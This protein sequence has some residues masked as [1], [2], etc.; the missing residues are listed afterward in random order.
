MRIKDKLNRLLH[1][2]EVDR[3]VLFGLLTRFWQMLTGPVTL[4]LIARHMKPE[5][6]GFYY[7]FASLL[8]LQSFVE[9]GF[10]VVIIN[11]AS[12]E[13]ASLKLDNIGRI[14]GES[15]ALSRLVSLGRLTFKWYAAASAI[16]VVGVGAAGFVF[17]SQ[18]S[19]PGIHWQFPW[20]VLVLLAGG[21][22]WAL[23]F[24]SLLEG[25]N[26]MGTV[27]RFRLSQVVLETAA[28]WIVLTLGGGLWAAVASG[29]VKW[30]RDLYLLLVQYRKFFEP[31]FRHPDGAQ[32]SWKDEV[33]PMQWRLALAGVVNYFAFSLFTPVM[34]QYHGAVVA[35]QMGMTWTIVGAVQAVALIWVYTKVPKFGMLIAQKDFVELDR[36]WLRTSLVSIVVV[37]AGAVGAWTLF[38]AL[39][40]WHIRFADRLLGPLPLGLLLT[41]VVLMQFTQCETAYLRAHKR[42]PLMVLSVV[43]GILS[44]G[45]VWFL[46]RRFGPTGAAAGY[47]AVIAFVNLPWETAIWFK[48]RAAW[49]ET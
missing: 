31:F 40:M 3:A 24:N 21:T 2:A 34:F 19:Y 6:Q 32:I 20:L 4:L 28:L 33:F 15:H 26:Q 13:W 29:A 49:H 12:H 5:V 39:N 14:C 18:K 47:L 11:V 42:E 41:S 44:G 1:H 27:N 7:T 23:P 43:T 36:Y 48:C 37:C 46:G 30:L 22:L 38:Y 9:L 8:A 25:C 35:G 16:F 45:A 10:Y 17:F